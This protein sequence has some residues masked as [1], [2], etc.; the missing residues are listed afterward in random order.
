[1]A[2]SIPHDIATRRADIATTAAAPDRN[3]FYAMIKYA[4]CQ[5]HPQRLLM[6]DI[7]GRRWARA[8]CRAKAVLPP[9]RF[10]RDT[11]RARARAQ[12]PR[13]I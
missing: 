11:Y 8:T 2:A 10:L 4:H 7:V 13:V 3:G 5:R 12:E 1:M 6:H 9:L